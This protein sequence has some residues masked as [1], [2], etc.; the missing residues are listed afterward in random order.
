M[1]PTAHPQEIMW[2]RHQ[3]SHESG[4]VIGIACGPRNTIPI[5]STVVASWDP[6]RKRAQLSRLHSLLWHWPSPGSCAGR[7]A[8]GTWLQ[9]PANLNWSKITKNT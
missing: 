6:R 1:G 5:E 4:N 3:F 8:T 2:E 7:R 9:A